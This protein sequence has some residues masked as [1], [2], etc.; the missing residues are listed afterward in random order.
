MPGPEVLN[1]WHL[2]VP[3]SLERAGPVGGRRWKGT[4]SA[5]DNAGVGQTLSM[6]DGCSYLGRS[7]VWG[8]ALLPCHVGIGLAKAI[9]PIVSE[10]KTRKSAVQLRHTLWE[11]AAS[12]HAYLGDPPAWVTETENFLRQNVHVVFTHN[13]QRIT[14]HCRRSLEA[15][16][17]PF[18]ATGSRPTRWKW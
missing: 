8:A 3:P 7:G 17:F 9:D 1:V 11:E 12:A 14:E 10:E 4:V 15:A 13:T 5:P 16:C 2:G 6:G 18:W